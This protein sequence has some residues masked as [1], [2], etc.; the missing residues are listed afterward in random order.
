MHLVFAR[1]A[2]GYERCVSRLALVALVALASCSRNS[3]AGG[4]APPAATANSLASTPASATPP[5]PAPSANPKCA[6]VVQA[7]KAEL[8]KLPSSCTTDKDCTCY[9]GGVSNVTG[10][11]GVSDMAAARRIGTLTREFVDSRC[12]GRVNCAATRCLAACVDG[13]CKARR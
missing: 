11:G 12:E 9:S 5:P 1:R 13:Y 7:L 4:P 10:C 8:A 3:P 2:P 6:R